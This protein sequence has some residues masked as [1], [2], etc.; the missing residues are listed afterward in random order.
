MTRMVRVL[1]HIDGLSL[2]GKLGP[3]SVRTRSPRQLRKHCPDAKSEFRRLAAQWKRETAISGHLSK[4]VMHPAYQRIMAMGPSV[5]PLILQDLSVSP[6][7]WFWALHNLV[8]PGE[9]PAEGITSIKEARRAWLDWG[10][11]NNYL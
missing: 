4:I 11:R 1:D 5:I 7:H 6:A 3:W 2:T 10:V 8:A 9:D